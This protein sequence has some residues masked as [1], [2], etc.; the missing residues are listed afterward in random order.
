VNVLTVRYTDPKAPQLFARS[1]H[2]TGFAVLTEHPISHPLIDRV[3]ADWAAFFASPA[4]H[5]VTFQPSR[6]EGYFPFKTENA[7]DSSIKD[8]K[9]FFHL[10]PR[11]AMPAGMGPATR[12]M[13]D[14]LH[15]LATE[16][17]GWIDEN[18]PVE[19]RSR[20]SMPLSRM[21]EGS[22]ETLLR[23]I[24]YPPLRGDEEAGAIRAA[25]HEDI[26]LITLLPAATAP[27]LQVK[28]KDGSWLDVSCDPG[29]LV[30]NSG[31]MLQMCSGGYY[32]STTHQVVNPVGPES[33]LPRY[34]M[35]LFLHPRGDV[36]LSAEHTAGSYLRERLYEIGLLKK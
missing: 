7:K 27:G 34:S 23:P 6:Q 29:A 35:P 4:K 24:H 15:T 17:L 1:L 36:P 26:N 20:F 18:T 11:T 8:L 3:F 13:Y 30:I 32:V 16:L 25:A 5:E 33:R 10:Y 28:T 9:E 12:E 2:E 19:V 14:R 22:D 21:I 31:D